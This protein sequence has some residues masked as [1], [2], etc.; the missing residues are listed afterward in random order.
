MKHLNLKK[1]LQENTSIQYLIA[2]D[3][4][5]TKTKAIITDLDFN[6][7][8]EAIGPSSALGQGILRAW[9]SIIT[10]VSL[11]FTNAQLRAPALSK[12]AIAIGI[13]GANNPVWKNEFY[14]RNPGFKE[15]IVKTDGY[16]THLGALEGR[17]GV[18]VAI[19]TGSVGLLLDESGNTRDVSGWGY[20]SGDE[21]SGAWLGI[22]AASLT[23]K[24]IDHRRKNSAL[25]Q[26]VLKYCGGSADEFLKWLGEANQNSFAQLAPLV[27]EVAHTDNDAKNLLFEAGHEILLMAKA[28]DPNLSLPFSICGSLGTALIP[29]LPKE[30]LDKNTIPKSDSTMGALYLF[31]RE[32]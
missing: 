20:P 29:F 12:C 22:K 24:S 2:I 30:L 6:I 1:S 9:N 16:T 28:L 21:A 14:L 26:A 18:V 27:F 32:N 25:S 7:L 15:V 17:A 8:G 4:G 31:T 23:Q 10:T 13:S 5:G 19:G 3:G 11:A